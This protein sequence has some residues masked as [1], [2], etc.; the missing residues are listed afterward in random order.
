MSVNLR[1]GS[2]KSINL[3]NLLRR[4][5]FHVNVRQ[6]AIIGIEKAVKLAPKFV[7]YP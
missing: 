5:I 3:M 4:Q 1:L 7:H 2:Y 6:R